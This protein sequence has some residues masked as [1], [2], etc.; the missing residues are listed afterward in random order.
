VEAEFHDGDDPVQPVVLWGRL[1][2]SR[3]G[4]NISFPDRPS[5]RD[6]AVHGHDG[7]FGGF[8]AI[9]T[10]YI[11]KDLT[12]VALANLTDVDLKRITEHTAKLLRDERH[13]KVP[14]P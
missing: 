8:E 2:R 1:S 5:R 7:S 13:Y 4:G 12:L 9:L 14:P 11:E 3:S 10:R 6:R